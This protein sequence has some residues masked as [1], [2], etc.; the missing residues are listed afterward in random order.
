MVHVTGE[1][2]PAPSE[3]LTALQ[4]ADPACLLMVLVQLTGDR[5]WLDPRYTGGFDGP[6]AFAAAAPPPPDDVWAEI[7]VAAEEALQKFFQEGAVTLPVPDDDLMAEMLTACVREPVSTEYT[8]MA[9]EEMGLSERSVRWRRRPDPERLGSFHVAIIGAGVS[10]LCAAIGL[11]RLGVPFT[12]I[13][14]NPTVGGTWYENS[15]PGC[16]VDV[17]NHFYSYSFEPNPDWSD[18]YSRQP[19]L[20]AYFER[21][22]DQYDLRRHIRFSCE[23]ESARFRSGDGIWRLSLRTPS[24]ASETLEANV[25]IS[26]VGQLN[27][28]K[29]PSLPGLDAFEGPVF[30]SAGWR[31]DVDLTGK[32]VAVIG[33]GASA[34]QFA[35]TIA[36]TVGRLTI[37]QRSPI[38]ALPNPDYLRSV[39]DVQ[40]WL[41]RNIPFYAGWYRFSLL[42]RLGDGLWPRLKVD[43]DWPDQRRSI[44]R[45]ND[46]VRR[47]LTSYIVESLQHREDLIAKALPDYPPYSKRI[48]ADNNWFETLLRPN[49]ELVTEPIVKVHDRSL[50]TAD[51]VNRAADVII[52]GTGFEA[53]RL[54][55]PMLMEGRGGSLHEAWKG[56]DP[57]AYLG[58]GVPEF[59]NLFL[60][61]G[62][63]TNLGHGGSIIFHSECQTRYVL[64]CI[65]EMLEEGRHTMEISEAAYARYNEALDAAMADMIWSRVEVDSWYR[66]SKGR[67]VTNSP[68]RL[69]DY[70]SL[71]RSPRFDDWIFD[72]DEG[73]FRR[74][75]SGA[76]A[77]PR[78]S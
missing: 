27:R 51:G 62:P 45:N 55:W 2:P 1:R 3:L 50:E 78:P 46:K 72:R 64:L 49:V 40:R 75:A 39:S 19:E 28:P 5:R 63:N 43:P 54:L 21:C 67:V 59:P 23:V 73:P 70:W 53:T 74:P 58:I 56:D 32:H 29:M 22:A 8:T 15:Y 12:V 34:M 26:A 48:L 24:G 35:P 60:L 11:K 17:A 6:R 7:V 41:F 10:G 71:T 44:N 37:F 4:D 77:T 65:R 66:N 38:W 47:W 20:R 30:H 68:W 42:W 9:L 14:K 76:A 16:R 33:T 69:V 61:Y 57:R 18:F 31:H 25:V 52:C 36:P 13:E